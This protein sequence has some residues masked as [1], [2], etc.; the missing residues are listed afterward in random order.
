MKTVTVKGK[1]YQIGG[2]YLDTSCGTGYL[3]SAVEDVPSFRL[4]MN[5]EDWFACRISAINSV[6]G[7]IE[8]APIELENGE[9]Y[10]FVLGGKLGMGVYCESRNSFVNLGHIVCGVIQAGM[11]EPLVVK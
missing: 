3:V 6:L 11:I 10:S 4:S 7:T 1:V 9:C 2:L 5:G 8:D